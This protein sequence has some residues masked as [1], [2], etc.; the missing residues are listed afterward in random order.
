M[1]IPKWLENAKFFEPMYSKLEGENKKSLE[2]FELLNEEFELKYFK[3]DD[4]I[5]NFHEF[6]LILKI[7]K[8]LI[9]EIPISIYFYAYLNYEE[10]KK[11]LEKKVEDP[12]YFDI[13]KNVYDNIFILENKNEVVKYLKSINYDENVINDLRISTK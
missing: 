2:Y 6:K 7:C 8:Y 11:Y 1:E 9:N 3:E 4:S 5:S 13:L 10:V 12:Y